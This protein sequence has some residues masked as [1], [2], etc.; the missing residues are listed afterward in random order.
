MSYGYR[1]SEDPLWT[2]TTGA[3]SNENTGIM[4]SDIFI[5]PVSLFLHGTTSTDVTVTY[6]IGVRRDKGIPEFASGAITWMTPSG[7]GAITEFTNVNL[8]SANDTHATLTIAS[9]K[10]FRFNVSNNDGANAIAEGELHI[11]ASY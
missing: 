4:S 6:Q 1:T 10:Y 7:G 5:G 9:G 2:G 8:T 3:S 11:Q